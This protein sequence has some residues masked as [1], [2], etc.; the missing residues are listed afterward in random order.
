MRR[1]SVRGV[2]RRAF[3]ALRSHAS[4]LAASLFDGWTRETILQASLV[5]V[6]A[7]YATATLV[8]WL[9]TQQALAFAREQT[10]D[11]QRP[12]ITVAGIA[13]DEPLAANRPVRL[14]VTIK[15]S[16]QSPAL[17]AT[18]AGNLAIRTE[19]PPFGNQLPARD[20]R[21][22]DMGAGEIRLAYVDWGGISQ[23]QP[24]DLAAVE[25]GRQ[26]LYATVEVFYND[27]FQR[28]NS[29]RLCA[30]YRPQTRDLAAC[31]TGNELH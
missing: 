29:T 18:I 14:G 24:G 9:S 15:N 2:T 5:L 20:A 13:L 30:V 28:A 27:V 11:A 17:R 23:L 3:R 4:D 26:R 25:S 10:R 22:T 16:G 7:L 6:V 12:W 8:L 31:A 1:A 19:A 21:Q